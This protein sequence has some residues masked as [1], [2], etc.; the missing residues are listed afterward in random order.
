MDIIEICD[1]GTTGIVEAE[2]IKYQVNLTLIEEPKVGDYIINHAG[3]AIERLDIVEARRRIE[4][5]NEIA[6]LAGAEGRK[7]P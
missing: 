4:L 2:G 7:V 5:F 3:F 6:E 1:D